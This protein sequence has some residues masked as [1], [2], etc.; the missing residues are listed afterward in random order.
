MKWA[1]SYEEKK[2]SKV[3]QEEIKHLSKPISNNKVELV[4]KK[5]LRE[6]KSQ[7]AWLHREFYQTYKEES[8]K[9]TYPSQTN[10]KN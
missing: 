3:A 5:F 4:I 9:H 10:P 2:L 1:N 6:K 8:I 7:T